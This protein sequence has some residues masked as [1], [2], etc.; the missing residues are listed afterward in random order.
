LHIR[1][2]K[3]EEVVSALDGGFLPGCEADEES[4]TRRGMGWR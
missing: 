3:S 4:G 2:P 1:I